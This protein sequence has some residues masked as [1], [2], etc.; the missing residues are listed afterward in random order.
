MGLFLAT[1]V[2]VVVL[3][4]VG[5]LLLLSSTLFFSYAL[6][7][8]ALIRLFVGLFLAVAV[9]AVAGTAVV[10]A[11]LLFFPVSPGVEVGS[12]RSGVLS[13]MAVA[14]GGSVAAG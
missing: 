12:G 13:G 4:G 11:F 8:G 3:S 9:V 7:T 14:V 5:V 6:G 1:V 2:V 10:T